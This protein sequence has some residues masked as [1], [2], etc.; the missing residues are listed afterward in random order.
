M[1]LQKQSPILNHDSKVDSYAMRLSNRIRT[2]VSQNKILAITL[3]LASFFIFFRI[4]HVDMLGDDA[5][6]S[7]RSIG[8]VDFMF[9]DV[10]FQPTPLQ[11]FDQ[12]PLWARLSFHDH[13]LVLF[14]IQHFF[15]TIHLSIFFSKLPYALMALGTMFVTYT[16]IKK[17]FGQRVA[18]LSAA[19][20]LLNAHFIWQG[21]VAFM[22]SGVLFFI[23][24]ACYYFIL[25]LENPKKWLR[26]GFF[27]GLLVEVKFTTLFIFPAF[28]TYLIIKK[29]SFFR[30]VRLY[31]AALVAVLVVLPVVIYNV[32]MYS[33]RGH[34]ALQLARLFHQSASPWHLSGVGA[35]S[36]VGFFGYFSFLGGLISY[37]FLVIFVL[38]IIYTLI[39]RRD[40]LLI[41]LALGFFI[42]E[43]L[44][45]G[46]R[47]LYP[48]FA[49]S[50]TAIAGYDLSQRLALK[51]AKLRRFF[52]GFAVVFS[53]YLLFFMARSITLF[54]PQNKIYA[55][56]LQSSEPMINVGVAQMDSYLN[57]LIARDHSLTFLDGYGD[58]K[59]K[60]NNLQKY[61]LRLTTDELEQKQS[62]AR[63]IIFDGN[64]NWFAR[65]WLFERRRFY[66]NVPIFSLNEKQILDQLSLE[67]YY[68]IKVT[69]D[70][71]L[72]PYRTPNGEAT[73]QNITALGIKPDL[74]YRND[75]KVAF[76]IYH[77]SQGSIPKKYD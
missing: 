76:K 37:P 53:A 12:M 74:V 55:G 64:I 45:I 36:G 35:S 28:L 1:G 42:V 71:P 51:H 5:H 23:S 34:F 14:I 2:Y 65:V 49:A 8:L 52:L 67:D 30:D 25:F 59:L 4:S 73:E 58:L 50:L 17:L 77:V 40:A 6:Y 66:Q 68:F 56:W 10:E 15:L 19:L 24:L 47:D 33:A 46:A 39:F 27:L 16:W 63:I 43:D 48:V 3:L 41:H 26:F 9:S 20:F 44:L 72:D 21:R 7:V 38:S 54:S 11:W 70:G 61:L 31:Y 29:R 62:H 13:P 18:E 32:A 22:E 60:Q 75:G 57:S 69:E